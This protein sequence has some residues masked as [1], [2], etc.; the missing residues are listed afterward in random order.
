MHRGMSLRAAGGKVD[1]HRETA[2]IASMPEGSCAGECDEQKAGR[3]QPERRAGEINV[4][5]FRDDDCQN[6]QQNRRNPFYRPC[7]RDCGFGHR[8]TL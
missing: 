4:A 6:R 1:H 2:G 5:F 3:Y 7:E 8:P